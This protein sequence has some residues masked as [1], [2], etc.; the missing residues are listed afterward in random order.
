MS[1]GVYI[2]GVLIGV[3]VLNQNRSTYWRVG[4]CQRMGGV[5]DCRSMVQFRALARVIVLCP[6][7]RRFTLIVPLSM[8]I[9]ELMLG[10]TL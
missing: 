7:A 4:T 2:I 3:W 6:W 1:I 8:G 5:L 9:S 10:A